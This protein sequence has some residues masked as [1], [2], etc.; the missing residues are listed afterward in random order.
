MKKEASFLRMKTWKRF[1]LL[2]SCPLLFNL[3]AYCSESAAGKTVWVD[4][5]YSAL[6]PHDVYL[7]GEGKAQILHEEYPERKADSGAKSDLMEKVKAMIEQTAKDIFKDRTAEEIMEIAR[8]SAEETARQISGKAFIG[9]RWIDKK[10]NSLRSLAVVKHSQLAG[11]LAR[12]SEMA[13][14]LAKKNLKS[15][16]KHLKKRKIFFSIRTYIEALRLYDELAVCGSLGQSLQDRFDIKPKIRVR[17]ASPSTGKIEEK[18]EDIITSIRLEKISGDTQEISSGRLPRHVTLRVLYNGAPVADF[19]VNFSLPDGNAMYTPNVRSDDNGIV[20]C[21]ISHIMEGKKINRVL[22]TPD[23]PVDVEGRKSSISMWQKRLEKKQVVFTYFVFSPRGLR[24][25]IDDVALSMAKQTEKYGE[26]SVVV[27]DFVMSD[28]SDN[29]LCRYFPDSLAS[30]LSSVG[31]EHL[32]VKRIQD[33]E[34]KRKEAVIT[35]IFTIAGSNITVSARLEDYKGKYLAGS[36]ITGQR[37]S[38]IDALLGKETAEPGIEEE[39]ESV[40]EEEETEAGF[41]P[42]M[43]SV[44]P[45]TEEIREELPEALEEVEEDEV[46]EYYEEEEPVIRLKKKEEA[47]RRKRKRPRITIIE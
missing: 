44:E 19:P 22:V 34:K 11:I 27:E 23:L 25:W 35:G 14:D 43:E 31:K 5:R 39:W 9:A 15:A 28:R 4:D 46:E 42:T 12:Q 6:Y 37:T 29:K 41:F 33:I 18:I 17:E 20:E 36:D 38:K 24:E 1:F 32:T 30:Q 7:A 26:L 3:P 40:E 8:F 2:V 45:G 16:K 10:D 21:G 47:P 13:N